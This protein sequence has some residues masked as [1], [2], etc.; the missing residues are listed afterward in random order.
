[1]KQPSEP[2][3]CQSYSTSA[4]YLGLILDYKHMRMHFAKA[5]IGT[6]ANEE[7][8]TEII[9]EHLCRLGLTKD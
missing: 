2:G 6:H 5:F 8:E 3:R 1:M 4:T 9:M 7:F